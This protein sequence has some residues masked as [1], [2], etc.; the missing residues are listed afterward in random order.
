MKT[1]FIFNPCSGKN[2]RN[3]WLVSAIRTFIA[4]ERLDADLVFTT[5]PGHAT[6]LTR[7]ALDQGC[8][9]VVAVGGDG[10][11]NEVAQALIGTPAALAL[12]PCGSGNG[13]ALHLGLPTRPRH[14][15]DLLADATA[16]TVAID[17]GAANGHPFFNAMG[18]GFDAEISRRFNRL[19]RRGL[20]AYART[21]IAA[22]LGHRHQRV[23]ISDG[24]GQRRAFDAFIVAV[25]N[26]DQYGNYARVAPGARVDDGQLDL[27]AVGP[28]GILG[29]LPLMARLFLGTFDGSRHVWRLRGSRFLV[30]R[31]APGLIHTDGETHETAAAV[32]IVVR[33]RSLRLLVP[34]ACRATAP[35]PLPPSPLLS[36]TRNT[37]TSAR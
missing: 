1:R 10:T 37:Y 32:E 9:R 36:W 18:L 29:A 22:F 5:E 20:P 12:L 13:L 8:E 14:A 25:A 24:I 6:E 28:P 15:L 31:P 34:A 33:P 26:S 27:V 35:A 7:R 3:P 2:R 19:T 16:R 17:T 4:Q 11:M 21:V 30:E 23:T